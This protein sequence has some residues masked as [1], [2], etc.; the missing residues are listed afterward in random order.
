VILPDAMLP[1]RSAIFAAPDSSIRE[2]SFMALV[3]KLGRARG[4]CNPGEREKFIREKEL[5]LS[6][7]LASAGVISFRARKDF[8]RF[9]RGDRGEPV[10]T[11]GLMNTFDFDAAGWRLERV[12]QT[13]VKT[14]GGP[15]SFAESAEGNARA[16][17]RREKATVGVGP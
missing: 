10:R 2:K 15:G 3:G 9:A 4:I 8:V 16:S 5:G 1:V 7:V 13:K 17:M 6:Q 12:F 14:R 11:W